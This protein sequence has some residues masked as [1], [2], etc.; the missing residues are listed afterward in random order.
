[1]PQSGSLSGDIEVYPGKGRDAANVGCLQHARSFPSVR[2]LLAS[3]DPLLRPWLP[4]QRWFA[5][6]GRPVTGF[7]LVAATELLPPGP[8]GRPK[9]DSPGLLHL[10]VRAQQP[11]GPGPGA[12]T[13]PGDTYQLLIGVRRTLPPR[14]AP[15]LIGRPADGPLA[16]QAVYEALHDA[17]LTEVLLERLRLPGRLGAL[18]FARA[19][20]GD[21][22][23][24][25][26]ARVL[27][28]E[29][30]N[31]SLVYGERLILKLF[32]R[33][34]PGVN[35]DLELPRALAAG[36]STR[37]PA[38]LAWLEADGARSRWSSAS[39][40][41]SCAAA[42]TAGSWRSARSPGV[43]TSPARPARWAGP[44]PRCTRHW[45]TPCPP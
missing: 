15:A 16:G 24:G 10:L 4:R 12:A 14:L 33:V 27:G 20:Q 43:R 8:P 32:R 38:P 22:P 36:R 9:P 41:R 28:A 40:S 35:P 26:P 17:R 29:Q 39:S 5:G 42:T 44:P 25:L 13:D 23:A 30:S 37:V 21:I 2:G 45:P 31:S 1:M 18:R 11:A 34:V 6:K 19:E 3:L 7:T